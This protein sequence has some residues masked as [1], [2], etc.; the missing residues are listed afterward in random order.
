MKQYELKKRLSSEVNST[1]RTNTD[2]PLQAALGRTPGSI[3]ICLEDLKPVR[4]TSTEAQN[5][6]V[7]LRM[8][9]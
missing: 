4:T 3:K 9:Q 2:D 6:Y 8:S 5:A 1:A 7:P